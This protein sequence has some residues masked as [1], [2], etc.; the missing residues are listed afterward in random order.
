VLGFEAL[1]RNARKVLMTESHPKA[2]ACLNQAAKLLDAQG[3]LDIL[4][5]DALQFLLQR[6]ERAAADAAQRFDVVFCDPP[7]QEEWFSRLWEPLAAVLAAD[8]RVYAES[9]RPLSPPPPWR[10]LKSG[11]AGAVHYH[12]LKLDE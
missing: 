6:G 12:L 3:R 7:F 10:V 5:A 9:A 4:G 11:K 1:S 8:G 2:R